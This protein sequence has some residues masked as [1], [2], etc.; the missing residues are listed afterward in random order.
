MKIPEKFTESRRSQNFRNTQPM[1][2]AYKLIDLDSEDKT[3]I[4]DVRVFWPNRCITCKSVI[5]I[6]SPK[7][8]LYG[9]GVGI[10][11][12]GGYHHES[13]A[14][15]YAFQDMGIEFEAGE[16]FAGCGTKAQEK[17]IKTIG[18]ALG[19]KST[20]LVGFNP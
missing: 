1:C 20:L 14:I 11:S 8:N 7:G 3:V 9:W 12:G 6:N 5:W 16:A 15:M 4:I 19:Y 17:A 18:E 13:V 2:L 10:T